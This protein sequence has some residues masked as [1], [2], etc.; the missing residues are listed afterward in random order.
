MN[1]F[2]NRDA[3]A[4]TV[5]A[6]PDWWRGAVIYQIYPRSFQDSNGDGMGDLAGITERLPYVAELG[7]DALWISP[8]FTSPMHDFGYDVANYRN[9][10]SMFGDLDAFDALMARAHAL[11][12]KVIIDLV[13][14]HTSNQH[15]W[16]VQSAS[17]RDNERSDWYVWAD[18][19]E[20]GS[21]PNNWLSFFGGSAWTWHTRRCQY[22]LHNFLDSQPDLNFH[23][24]EVQTALLDVAKFWLDRGV[25][26]FRLDTVNFYFCD[27]QLRSNPALPAAHRNAD[28]TPQVNL[29]NYQ[30]HLYDKNRPETLQFLERFRQVLDEQPA[31]TSVGEI[32]DAQY[33]MRLLNDYTVE[34]KRLH[35]CYTF[36]F[37]SPEPPS[38]HSLRNTL[39]GFQAQCTDSWLCL[40]FSNH[41]VVRH[42]TRWQVATHHQDKQVILYASLLLSLRGSVCLYQG[43]EL[44]LSEADVPYDLLQDP[45][46]LAFWPEYKGRDGC[47]TPMP[48]DHR[49]AHAG[50]S[51]ADPWLPIPEAHRALAVT[52][53]AASE[54]STLTHY[55]RFLHFR[56]DKPALRKG[57]LADIHATGDVL[58]FRRVYGDE[59]VHCA[60]NLGAEEVC[61]QIE[62][63]ASL[64]LLSE[65][66]F[67]ATLDGTQLE[68]PAYGAA[69]VALEP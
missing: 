44:G 64:R 25:D 62:T 37:L 33:G 9:V 1:E 61:C 38:A 36:D 10:D 17:S 56:R 27:E 43:E 7:V 65:P 68:L 66:G 12:L 35:Q 41:D 21:P 30:D 69:F 23:Q 6:D 57:D 5:S 22:F 29:Y 26:G 3:L 39:L 16:F 20:D 31:A 54:T 60:F 58:S 49:E 53:Q 50:F 4:P 2:N 34:G 47:R 11:G 15:E 51:T 63:E 24:P 45:Y 14:S 67:K 42:A 32:G 55:R 13:L 19:R 59:I 46:G 52:L 40:A 8:F 48:W 18:A 28:F